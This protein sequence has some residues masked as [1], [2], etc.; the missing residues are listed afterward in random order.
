MKSY[1][2]LFILLSLAAPAL[3]AAPQRAPVTSATATVEQR[4]S[5]LERKMKSQNMVEL[6]LQIQQLQQEVQQLRGEL[7]IQNNAVD[8]LKKRQRDLYLDLDGRISNLQQ[9]VP[10]SSPTAVPTPVPTPVPVQGQTSAPVD[11]P[12][13]PVTMVKPVTADPAQEESSYQSAFELLKQARY[14]E[15]ITAFK[16]FLVSYPDG[17]YTDNAQYW[18]GE[19]SYVTRDFDQALIDFDKVI[20][21]HPTSPKVR[22]AMLKRGYIYYEQQK[23]DLARQQLQQLVDSHPNSSEARL[24]DKRLARMRQEKR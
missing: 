18:L 12:V 17:S 10:G 8:A 22:G 1:S 14:A 19:T 24:A 13:V 21:N 2:G 9:P 5:A 3:I 6:V 15:A 23:W 4:L 20:Q 11:K 16:Q 7:E